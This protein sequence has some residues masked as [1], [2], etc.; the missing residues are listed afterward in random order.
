MDL[1]TRGVVESKKFA[2][3]INVG[4]MP[5]DVLGDMR[6]MFRRIKWPIGP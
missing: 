1:Q 2:G 5:V 4:A 6:T 3:D